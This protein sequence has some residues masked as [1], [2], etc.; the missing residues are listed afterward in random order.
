MG[1]RGDAI[2][3]ESIVTVTGVVPTCVDGGAIDVPR[4]V[5][6][7]LAVRVPSGAPAR[8]CTVVVRGWVTWCTVSITG[9]AGLAVA[10]TTLETASRAW[11]A[12]AVIARPAVVA[13]P[14]AGVASVTGV[15][16]GAASAAPANAADRAM[17]TTTPA[18]PPP[19]S[20]TARHNLR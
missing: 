11:R 16:G 7:R 5:A 13:G 2:P 10:A 19:R 8:L 12:G 4:L 6:G 15:G 3:G 14:R 17:P 9:A 1:A 20:S 18:V